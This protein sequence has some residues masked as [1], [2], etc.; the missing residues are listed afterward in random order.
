[1]EYNFFQIVNFFHDIKM[2]LFE[3]DMLLESFF[4]CFNRENL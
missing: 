2:I 4:V 3:N 1:M